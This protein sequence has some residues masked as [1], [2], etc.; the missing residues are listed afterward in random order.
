MARSAMRLKRAWALICWVDRA[1]QRRCMFSG[2]R[3]AR[4]VVLRAWVAC[5]INALSVTLNSA[6]AHARRLRAEMVSVGSVACARN[7]WITALIRPLSLCPRAANASSS[8]AAGS[9]ARARRTSGLWAREDMDAKSARWR[10]VMSAKAVQMA[11]TW[12]PDRSSATPMHRSATALMNPSFSYSILAN[13][14]QT[15]TNSAAAISLSACATRVAM[16]SSTYSFFTPRLAK[17][18]TKLQRSPQLRV[19]RTCGCIS[20]PPITITKSGL[21]FS[22]SRCFVAMASTSATSSDPS[23]HEISPPS[24]ILSMANA[25]N[26]GP[27][28]I[29]T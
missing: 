8:A 26:L 21:A 25:T 19:L 20:R 14:P 18:R 17:E 10:W 12:S 28:G 6:K 7:C 24:M 9:G 22:P 11:A 16:V 23:S 3:S 27:K 13:A 29:P 2:V 5:F 1:Q 15:C 4:S